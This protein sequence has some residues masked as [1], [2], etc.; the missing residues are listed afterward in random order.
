MREETGFI[1]NNISY[2]PQSEKCGNLVLIGDES[3]P[4]DSFIQKLE[5]PVIKILL[6]TTGIPRTEIMKS[7]ATAAQDI[8]LCIG[9]FSNKDFA[10]QTMVFVLLQHSDI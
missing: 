1:E 10:K 6:G 4:K 3:H 9:S 8:F 7:V 2:W 5:N